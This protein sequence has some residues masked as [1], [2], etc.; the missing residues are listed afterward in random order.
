MNFSLLSTMLLAFALSSVCLFIAGHAQQVSGN[1]TVSALFAFG[2]SILDTGNNNN[3]RTQSKCNFFP[4]G[5]DFTGGKATGRCGNGRIFSDIIAEGLSIK[6]LLPAYRDPNLSN[7]DLPTGVCFASVGSGL[8]ERTAKLQGVVWVPDQVKDFNEYVT[9]LNGVVGSQEKSNAVLSNAVYLISAGNN[10]LAITFSTGRTR[11]TISAYADL[12]VTW[13]DNL[14]KSL[15]DMGARKF[16]VMGTLPLGCLPGARNVAGN[17]LK[18]C[19]NLVNQGADLFNKKLSEKLNNLETTLPGAK[20]AYVDMYNPLLNLI[21]NP[22]ASGFIDVAD[23]CCCMP[24]SPVPCLDAA[25]YV[26]W[27]F[28]HPSEKSYQT[29][30]P[31]IIEELKEKLA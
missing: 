3:L 23:G 6:T 20:F 11:Y 8:D 29:I 10:D 16:G 1:A 9:K 24:T 27:D 4:Y 12:L 7:N 21:N 18:I 15:Y 31:K 14:I 2:D 26:F 5:R 22:Q 28:A 13:T 19:S 17:Y 25:R 30:A